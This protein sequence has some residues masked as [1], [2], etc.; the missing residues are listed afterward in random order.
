M[1]DEQIKA[2]L[3][4]KNA[5]ALKE[6][7]KNMELE[8]VRIRNQAEGVKAI[9][10]DKES[11]QTSPQ[12]TMFEAVARLM[13]AQEELQE[14]IKA[15][16]L[17]LK[18]T[19]TIFDKMNKTEVRLLQL[20]YLQGRGYPHICREM[21]ISERTAKRISAS[22]LQ[23]FGEIMEDEHGIAKETNL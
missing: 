21:H 12:D 22:G 16:S 5:G 23:H 19:Y 9:R 4:L 14:K 6:V 1:T 13:E 17:E 3:Y 8:I 11:V 2:K 7:I 15:Y 10:Y 20:R 18:T